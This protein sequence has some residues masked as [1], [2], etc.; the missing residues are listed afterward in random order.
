MSRS[1]LILYPHGLFFAEFEALLKDA[2]RQEKIHTAN[3]GEI[4][5]ALKIKLFIEKQVIPAIKD[6]DWVFE[7]AKEFVER[8]VN[9]CFRQLKLGG[10]EAYASQKRLHELNNNIIDFLAR[11]SRAGLVSQD[12]LIDLT[13]ASDFIDLVDLNQ[14]DGKAK[15]EV[16]SLYSEAVEQEDL[17]LWV[18]LRG[19]RDLYEITLPRIMYV[20][21][22][23]IKVRENLPR[24]SS[25]QDLLGISETL[26]WYESYIAL[27][28]LLFPVIGDLRPFY[29]VVRNVVSHHKGL[30]WDS[31]SDTIRLVDN[32]HELVMHVYEFQQRYRLLLYMCEFGLRGI[33]FA[34]CDRE[35][36][37]LSNWLVHEYTKTFPEDLPEG[38]P[39]RIRFYVV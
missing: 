11:M 27:S 21:R 35:R 39:A 15:K 14:L 19:I 17:H 20:I 31:S 4:A 37:D 1:S 3:K 24:K 23:A 29:K 16:E 7:G 10:R 9:D 28:H 12:E 22:R 38:I 6:D 36:G 25:D 32:S 18:T 5:H 33:L 30:E 13:K 34:F 2:K 26:D 8:Y